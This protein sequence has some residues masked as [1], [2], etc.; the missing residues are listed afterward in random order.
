MHTIISILII[1]Y[2]SQ[3]HTFNAYSSHIF[4]S[5]ALSSIKPVDKRDGGGAHN[6]GRQDD[7]A[8]ADEWP[9]DEPEAQQDTQEPVANGENA[10]DQK[11]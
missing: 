1:H 4:L 11:L 2:H 6:W 3:S 9:N 7:G 5:L 8:M 10:L